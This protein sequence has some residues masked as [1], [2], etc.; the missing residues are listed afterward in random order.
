MKKKPQTR[1]KYFQIMYPTK[2]IRI[3][4]EPSELNVR[5]QSNLKMGKMLDVKPQQR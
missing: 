3:Y 4:K 2:D 1:H 5:K